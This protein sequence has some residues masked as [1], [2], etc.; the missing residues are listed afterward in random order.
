MRMKLLRNIT[1]LFILSQGYFVQG[2]LVISEY[3]ASNM[4][5]FLDNFGKYEDFIELHNTSSQAMDIG[6]FGISDKVNKP[7]KWV[8]DPGTTIG[9][10]E[11]IVIWCSGRDLQNGSFHS[12]FKITQTKDNEAILLSDPNGDVIESQDYSLTLLAHSRVKLSDG[13]WAVSTLPSPGFENGSESDFFM[14]YTAEP[15]ISVEAGFYDEA[16]EVTVANQEPNSILRYTLDGNAP[17]ANSPEYTGPITINS[18]Q[19]LKA[20][21]YSNDSNIL[22]GKIAFASYFIDESFT[23]PVISIAADQIQDLANG[24]G[25]IRPIG[26]I[27]Y[28]IDGKLSS[29]SYGELNRHGQDSW[30]ND[31]RS[32]DWVSR[33]EMGYSKALNEKL[34]SYSDRV[35][36]QRFMMRASGDDNY[37]SVDDGEHEGNTHM[38]DEY[39]HELAHRGGM[40]LD[41]RAVER[42]IVFLNGDYWG[43]YSPRERP[44][45]HDYTSY[46]Y[47]QGKFE[48]NYI[49]T[50][51]ETWTE[52]NGNNAFSEWAELR[53]FI[54]ENDMANDDNYQIVKDNIQ[55]TGMIDYFIVNLNTVCSDWINYNTGWWEGLNPDGDHKKWGYILWDNDAT[56][57]YYINYSGVPNTQPD[58]VPCDIEDIADFMDEMYGDGGGVDTSFIAE[59]ETIQNGSCP[60]PASD[61]I[62]AQ[63]IQ[64]DFECCFVDWNGDCQQ[65][66]DDISNGVYTGPDPETCLTVTNGQSP[67]PP[68]DTIF[69]QVIEVDEFCCNEGWDDVCQGLYDNFASGGAG[70][71]TLFENFGKHEKLFLK[72]QN[73]SPEFRQLY[74]SRQADMMNTVF[75]CD[76]MLFV[77]DSLTAIIEPEMPRHIDR[78]GGT[79]SEWEANLADL[80]SFVEQRCQ[81]LDDGMTGCFE[82]TGPFGLTLDVFPEG[83][84]HIDLNTI[85]VKEFPWTGEYFGNMDN[86]IDADAAP[87]YQFV[88]WETKNGTAVFPNE[89]SEEGSIVLTEADTLVAIFSDVVAVEETEEEKLFELLVYPS[90]TSGLIYINYEMTQSSEV[91]ISLYDL[92]GR[93]VTETNLG[94]KAGNQAHKEHM[95]MR[96]AG[97]ANGSYVV[98]IQTELGAEHRKIIIVK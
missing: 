33:D 47:D 26:S 32:L 89:S 83:G 41:V 48:L 42:T 90:P 66:Y 80:R 97:L 92:H 49:L 52:Y 15:I 18:T 94:I 17:T 39:V 4:N 96:R 54:L 13:S 14:G 24:Q 68:E 55:L 25:E 12:N 76:N 91:S 69:Q 11:Y 6:G 34:F 67:Y 20:A 51:G 93:L 57:D 79:V 65:L 88:R 16:F 46:Y 37:P 74:F 23:L 35:E 98:K 59:C 72:L 31:Q 85:E 30:I 21:A 27:E 86:L 19:V 73:E 77:L 63:V 28:F 44:V 60:Y 7:Q 36:Y 61:P 45:D 38:R 78:W 81:L 56:F 87:G 5:Q 43:V 22:P 40:K 29:S 64:E 70:G 1:L 53:D 2:Q 10:D 84:G 62:L 58:A 95:D 3:S 9:A 50:W 75:S 82:V 8:F 71:G